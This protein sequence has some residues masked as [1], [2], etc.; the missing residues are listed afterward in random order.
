MLNQKT[1]AFFCLSLVF[2]FLV[3]CNLSWAE[4]TSLFQSSSSMS[5]LFS[6]YK[7][8]Q[9]GDTVTIIIS[10]RSSSNQ[11]A[12][13]SS[14]KKNDVDIGEAQVGSYDNNIFNK[15]LRNVLPIGNESSSKFSG[16]GS[17]SRSGSLVATM[18]A[19]VTEILPNGNMALEGSQKITVN[20]EKQEIVVKGTV[21]PV[22]IN[23][24]NTVYSTAIANAEI[25]YK[26]KGTVN[27]S[28]R[29]GILSRFFHW[30]F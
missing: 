2:L 7:A 19:Q 8:R 22:D 11:A 25:S 24:D 20:G 21:R 4:A 14:S 1:K 6:D 3:G 27:E 18:T 28:Q 30:L 23:P 12:S 10:E 5:N 9:V 13:S 16:S 26:G 15:V 17:T 29:P